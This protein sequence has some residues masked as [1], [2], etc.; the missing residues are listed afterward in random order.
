VA[1]LKGN[2]QKFCHISYTFIP[3]SLGWSARFMPCLLVQDGRNLPLEP[4]PF[5]PM[6]L[7]K[8]KDVQAPKAGQPENRINVE[9]NLTSTH[10]DL[11]IVIIRPTAVIGHNE[12]EKIFSR[13]HSTH[14]NI[15]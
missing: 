1:V 11:H 14:G 8:N 4:E 2:L 13:R 12:L 3:K 7:Q 5:S 10:D 6:L 15:F 9:D